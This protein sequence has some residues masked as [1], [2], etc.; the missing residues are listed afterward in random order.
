MVATP[1]TG[2]YHNAVGRRKTAIARVRLYPGT[3]E[4]VVNGK[5]VREYFGGRELHQITVGTPLRITNT[6]DRFLVSVKVVGGGV[7]GQAGAIRHGIARALCRFDPEL[8]T[9]LKRAG[10]LT[11]DAR[12]KER[13]KVGLK[14]ARKAPQY[15]KR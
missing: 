1:L 10:L 6:A 13:K 4:M 5:E 12:V 11:R 8:R 7:S 15:T 2:Q 9:T 3:G 14:R